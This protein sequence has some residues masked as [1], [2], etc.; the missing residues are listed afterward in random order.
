M[1]GVEREFA[2]RPQDAVDILARV[3]TLQE[4][5]LGDGAGAF[6]TWREAVLTDPEDHRARGSLERL[7][8]LLD[9]WD[10]AAATW[11]D[12]KWM[13]ERSRE[14]FVPFLAGSSLPVT[15]LTGPG[16]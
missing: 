11:E 10:D 13:Y 7:A 5:R 14:L 9:L 15:W 6:I 4:E 2:A 3:A 16:P 1:R 8:R 12:A